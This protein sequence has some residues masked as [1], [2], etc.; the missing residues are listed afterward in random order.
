MHLNGS[1]NKDSTP[2]VSLLQQFVH[3]P[4]YRQNFLNINTVNYNVVTVLAIVKKGSQFFGLPAIMLWATTCKD[5]SPKA[6]IFNR[7]P[8]R[9]QSILVFNCL[10]EAVARTR[11]QLSVAIVKKGSQFFETFETFCSK[12]LCIPVSRTHAQDRTGFPPD[13]T[14]TK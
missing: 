2:R 10:G 6:G 12:A 11:C 8:Q 5:S 13:D 14:N 3:L 9:S 4:S 1:A 7:R